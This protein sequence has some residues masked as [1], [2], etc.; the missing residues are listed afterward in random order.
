MK[1]MPKFKSRKWVKESLQPKCNNL[2]YETENQNHPCV[3]E[4]S[5]SLL[6]QIE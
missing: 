3:Q 4:V 1:K 5:P 2:H 6:F